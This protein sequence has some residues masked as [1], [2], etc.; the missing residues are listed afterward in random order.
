MRPTD[1]IENYDNLQK[2]FFMFSANLL[3]F[4]SYRVGM[5]FVLTEKQRL[6]MH[7]TSRGHPPPSLTYLYLVIELIR[8]KTAQ[9][10]SIFYPYNFSSI[11]YAF[12][13]LNIRKPGNW[14]VN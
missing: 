2:V 3:H 10:A 5:Q 7:S 8:Q 11:I 9:D 12:L 14:S 13:S 4:Y 1:P 6:S